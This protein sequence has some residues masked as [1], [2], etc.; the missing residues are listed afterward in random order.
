MHQTV[1]VESERHIAS[2]AVRNFSQFFRYTINVIIKRVKDLLP[3]GH[4]RG[5]F[6]GEL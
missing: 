4:R 3:K 6:C 2:K 5:R 1:N